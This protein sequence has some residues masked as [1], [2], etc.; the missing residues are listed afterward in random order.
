MTPGPR[1]S[2]FFAGL[3]AVASLCVPLAQGNTQVPEPGALLSRQDWAVPVD[4]GFNLYRMTPQ[5][6][7][8]ALPDSGDLPQLQRLGV[9]TVVSFIKEDDADWLGDAQVQRV[10]IPLHADRVDDVDVLRVL[11]VLQRAEAQGPVLMH[12]K[13]GRDRTGLMAAMYRTVVQGW[14]RA[15]ALAEMKAGGFGDARLMDDAI[16]YVEG[17]DIDGLRQ[18]LASGA[19]STRTLAACQ[20]GRWLR[21]TFGAQPDEEVAA[22]G[23]AEQVRSDS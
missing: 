6:Y 5:L 3:L 17:A 1:I 15:D 20:V 8:S 12:C 23:A 14:S 22:S 9:R 13:H 4:R 16:A 21:A 2:L 11:R 7:R 10:S 19:C 18:A